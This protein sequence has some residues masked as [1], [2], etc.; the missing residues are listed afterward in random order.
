MQQDGQQF[1]IAENGK[2]FSLVKQFDFGI[3]ISLGWRKSLN[4]KKAFAHI[5]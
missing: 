4:I 3:M 5:G 1:V 2:L